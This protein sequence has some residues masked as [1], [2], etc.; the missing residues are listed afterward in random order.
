MAGFGCEPT[1]KN[2]PPL[3]FKEV[4]EIFSAWTSKAGGGITTQGKASEV[5]LIAAKY[6]TSR[7]QVG[8]T[9]DLAP[10]QKLIGDYPGAARIAIRAAESSPQFEL[11]GPSGRLIKA[12]LAKICPSK[13]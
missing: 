8:E 13:K 12:E 7:Q 6:I 4:G 10:L 1:N 5:I 3:N 9:P 2:N 11:S